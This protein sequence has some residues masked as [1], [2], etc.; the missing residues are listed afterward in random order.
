MIRLLPFVIAL[1]FG[2]LSS[3]SAHDVLAALKT[4]GVIRMGYLEEA[5]PFSA[6]GASGPP[7]GFSVELCARV[8]AAI[9]REIE[10]PDLRV[11]WVPVT[12]ADRF[13]AVAKGRVEIECST[14]TWTFSRQKSVEFSLMIFVDGGTIL[15]RNDSDFSRVRDFAG[16]RV[17][18]VRNTTTQRS[19]ADALQRREMTA[20]IVLFDDAEAA[21]AALRS[22][23]VDG[24]ASDR[25]KLLGTALGAQGAGGFRL[26]DEDFSMEPYALAMHAGDPG[27]RIAVNR[28]LAAI[29]RSGD[30]SIVYERWLAP[31][32]K[33]SLL[34]DAL[35]YLQ[36]IPE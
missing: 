34:L 24:Y 20:E 31:L 33:P 14:S 10:R 17:A 32:G 30:I 16:K 3:A 15:I 12:L 9:G 5:P 19:V 8:A 35:Y 21:L 1:W 4:S 27:F 11:E 28:A 18:V 36:R 29:Y 25:V 6:R 26:L 22:G 13:E 2:A 23:A 7:E